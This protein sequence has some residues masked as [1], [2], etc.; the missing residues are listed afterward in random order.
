[1]DTGLLVF[2]LGIENAAQVSRDPLVGQMFENLVVMECVKH[3]ANQG[4]LPNLYFYRDSNGNEVDVIFQ[5]GR[6][7][8]AIE[9]K[10]SS[11]YNP[12]M[13]KG[14]KKIA[15]LT[16]NIEH[17][18]LVYSGNNFDFSDGVRA[19]KYDQLKQIFEQ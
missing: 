1:M 9:I 17:A 2:L 11:T 7:L 3:R 18:Y 6:R 13:L 15:H 12:A 16:N 10:S 5:H 4:K 14:L 8:T 19:L